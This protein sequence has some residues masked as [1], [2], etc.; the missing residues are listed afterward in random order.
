MRKGR[1]LARGVYVEDT[2]SGSRN[3]MSSFFGKESAVRFVESTIQHLAPDSLWTITIRRERSGVCSVTIATTD[4]SED[5][6]T[7]LSSGV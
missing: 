5:I 4:L 7:H 1:R 3:I 2:V 6:L